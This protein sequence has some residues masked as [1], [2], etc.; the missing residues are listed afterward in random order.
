MTDPAIHMFLQRIKDQNPD[1]RTDL[2][3]TEA[4]NTGGSI[5]T[6]NQP[7]WVSTHAFEI[8]LHDIFMTGTTMSEA[9]MKWERTATY[10][11]L[12]ED[13]GVLA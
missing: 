7:G 4:I 5:Q 9:M 2:F 1:T 6:P 12:D 11:L 8:H 13:K 10:C 3:E